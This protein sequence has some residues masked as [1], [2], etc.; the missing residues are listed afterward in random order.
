MEKGVNY[1]MVKPFNEDE[2]SEQIN[3]LLEIV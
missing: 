2:L 3:R 1:Y